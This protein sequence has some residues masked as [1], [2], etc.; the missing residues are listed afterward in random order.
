MKRV[1]LL[2]LLLAASSVA[3]APV[4][5]W[6]GE[7]KPES[8]YAKLDAVSFKTK[9]PRLLAYVSLVDGNKGKLP[10]LYPKQWALLNPEAQ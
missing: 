7:Y 1:A 4:L 6:C 9:S 2:I 5:R 8:T 10:P 3:N